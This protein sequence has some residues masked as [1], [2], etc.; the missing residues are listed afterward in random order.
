MRAVRKTSEEQYRLV[1]ECRQSGL[2][3]CD[4]CRENGININTFYA[5]V[6]RLR[7]EA[8]QPIPDPGRHHADNGIFAN[9]VVKVEILSEEQQDPS[10]AEDKPV[11][12]PTAGIPVIEIEADGILF[13][14]T[15]TVDASL[16]E[17]TLLMIGGRL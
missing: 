3:D 1:M 4:W 10:D 9:E 8:S 6:R 14:F 15:G 5:W 7:K 2:T 12:L 16:Y 11:P 17:K 13:R